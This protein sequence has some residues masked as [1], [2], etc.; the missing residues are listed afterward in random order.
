M[1]SIKSTA[2]SFLG[3]TKPT[4]APGANPT[5]SIKCWP[6]GLRDGISTSKQRF[7]YVPYFTIIQIECTRC[8]TSSALR[9]N[10]DSTMRQLLEKNGFN[11]IA[12][13]TKDKYKASWE[14]QLKCSTP[15]CRGCIQQM[16]WRA[17]LNTTV[18][19]Q[20][21]EA[22]LGSTAL[23]YSLTDNLQWLFDN[24]HLMDRD[25][26]LEHTAG[27]K[28]LSGCGFLARPWTAN[29]NSGEVDFWEI[30]CPAAVHKTRV[31]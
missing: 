30:L 14:P 4:E 28:W 31:S 5:R 10:L 13:S 27:S 9:L 2:M 23:F 16:I 12:T 26:F 3:S 11:L 22:I 18:V 7:I 15:W 21:S 29:P 8:G 25:V 19:D 17:F 24:A 20:L 6:S 1:A